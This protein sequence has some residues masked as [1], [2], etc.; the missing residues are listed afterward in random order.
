MISKFIKRCFFYLCIGYR[1]AVSLSQ[2][3]IL[4]LPHHFILVQQSYRSISYNVNFYP[5]PESKVTDT[6]LITQWGY[7]KLS[8]T[9]IHKDKSQFSLI[10]DICLYE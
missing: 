9:Q 7:S 5:Q 2:S 10:L 6:V 3:D 8:N 1:D 4:H